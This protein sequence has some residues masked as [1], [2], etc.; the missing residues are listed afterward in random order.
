MS[1]FDNINKDKYEAQINFE[2]LEN[3]L[4]IIDELDPNYNRPKLQNIKKILLQYN[5]GI[6][7]NEV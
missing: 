1:Y 5:L 7:N 6:R 2:R 3:V 4:T